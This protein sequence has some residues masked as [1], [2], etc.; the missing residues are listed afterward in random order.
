MGAVMSEEVDFAVAAW[1]ED[2]RWSLAKLPN[3]HDLAHIIDRLKSQRTNGG[4]IALIAIDE[5][6]FIIIRV[7][8]TH[9]SMFLSD[10]TCAFD[11]EVASDFIELADLPFPNEEDEPLP[12]GHLDILADLGM[13]HMEISALCDDAELF[14]EEQLDAIATR[15]GFGEEFRELIDL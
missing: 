9:I 4:A 3:P 13:N 6:F 15:L 10:V 5:E 7:L 1:H 12:V 11:Y 2:G 8:G 14:P